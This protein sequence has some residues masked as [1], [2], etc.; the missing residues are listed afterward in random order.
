MESFST[1]QVLNNRMGRLPN[2]QTFAVLY[3]NNYSME[4]ISLKIC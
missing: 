3:A 4:K 2:N 1:I